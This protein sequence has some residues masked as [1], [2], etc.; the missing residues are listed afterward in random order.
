MTDAAYL[1]AAAALTI[2][3]ETVFYIVVGYR[4]RVFL[5]ACVLINFITNVPLNFTLALM[6]ENWG[7]ILLCPLE[8]A[9]I[10]IEWGVL[11][12][13][14]TKRRGLAALVFL[15]NLLSFTVGV[16]MQL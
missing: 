7:L 12:L 13:F 9:I 5:T 14:T 11:R 16:L 10:F 8:I 3:I 6:P 4:S 2:L 15:A 1:L